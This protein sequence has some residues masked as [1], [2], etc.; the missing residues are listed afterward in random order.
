MTLSAEDQTFITQLR[1]RM[2]PGTTEPVTLDEM[3]R[4]IIIL[5]CKRTSAADASQ[6][7]SPGKRLSKKPSEAAVADALADLDSM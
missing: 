2:L 6:S 3:K 4:A 5:R 7:A 1:L